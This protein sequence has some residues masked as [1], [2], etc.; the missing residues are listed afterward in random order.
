MLLSGDMLALSQ[1]NIAMLRARP[2]P[3]PVTGDVNA[4]ATTQETVTAYCA[5]GSERYEPRAPSRKLMPL[6]MKR[7]PRNHLGM[8]C[9]S[10]APEKKK[11]AT[12]AAELR[13][14]MRC[15]PPSRR[16]C[17]ELPSLWKVTT[18]FVRPVRRQP[19]PTV[20]SSASKSTTSFGLGSPSGPAG[21]LP[22]IPSTPVIVQ[23]TDMR[24]KAIICGHAWNTMDMSASRTSYVV[25]SLV[26][27]WLPCA[28]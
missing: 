3:M 21:N 8:K 27:P 10:G 1:R 16:S 7:P 11:I 24:I 5:G 17:T 28:G 15:V 2:A 23:S 14:P 22:V 19:R 25:Q 26:K 18:P 13:M 20:V 12:N 6:P 4:A 9:P